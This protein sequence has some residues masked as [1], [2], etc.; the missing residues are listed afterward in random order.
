MEVLSEDPATPFFLKKKKPPTYCCAVRLFSKSSSIEKHFLY[1]NLVTWC[2]WFLIGAN[3]NCDSKPAKIFLL[4]GRLGYDESVQSGLLSLRADVLEV[5]GRAEGFYKFFSWGRFTA[6]KTLSGPLDTINCSFYFGSFLMQL[7]LMS[8]HIVQGYTIEKY[9]RN[10]TT[11]CWR[12]DRGGAL[13]H[14]RLW[15]DWHKL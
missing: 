11:T 7:L 12:Q 2:N 5:A 10:R 15:M 9:R 13:K 4:V 6:F 3:V 14:K 8:K 1:L